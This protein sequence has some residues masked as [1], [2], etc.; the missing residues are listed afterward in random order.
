MMNKYFLL[1]AKKWVFQVVIWEKYSVKLVWGCVVSN[2]HGRTD[3]GMDKAGMDRVAWFSNTHR[4]KFNTVPQPDPYNESWYRTANAYMIRNHCC[5]RAT[6]NHPPNGY[7]PTVYSGRALW[8][9]KCQR[10][11]TVASCLRIARL[12]SQWYCYSWYMRQWR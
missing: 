3:R 10:L 4:S 2:G 5:D 9:Y 1:A 11:S 8:G 6:D 12:S 7:K